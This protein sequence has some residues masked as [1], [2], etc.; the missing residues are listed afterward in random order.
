MRQ[1]DL[2]SLIRELRAELNEINRAIF[3]LERLERAAVTLAP[4]TRP[5]R[6]VAQS[7]KPGNRFPASRPKIQG[8]FN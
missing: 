5:L 7:L 8:G 3:S 6:K 2:V 1:T 4:A